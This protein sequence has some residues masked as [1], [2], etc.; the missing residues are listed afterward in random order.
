MTILKDITLTFGMV[1]HLP[2]FDA[3]TSDEEQDPCKGKAGDLLVKT[4]ASLHSGSLLHALRATQSREDTG[5][6]TNNMAS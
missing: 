3:P 4:A 5:K 2:P 6:A 1:Q